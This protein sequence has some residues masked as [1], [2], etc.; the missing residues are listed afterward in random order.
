M[1]P[2]R[3]FHQIG[4][5]LLSIFFPFVLTP[6]QRRYA[7]PRYDNSLV[8]MGMAAVAVFVGVI[9]IVV[10]GASIYFT[11][12][13]PPGQQGLALL[14]IQLANAI[15]GPFIA[16]FNALSALFTKYLN[17]SNWSILPIY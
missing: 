17:P 2:K 15:A 14:G 16:F 9:V 10:I 12:T 7:T 8:L 11:L 13:T 1:N 6:D 3:R 5:F 4:I